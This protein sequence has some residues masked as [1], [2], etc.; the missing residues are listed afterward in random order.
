MKTLQVAKSLARS[1]ATATKAI[2][3]VLSTRA[4][5]SQCQ[6]L[7]TCASPSP[8]RQPNGP[9][10][11]PSSSRAYAKKA[12]KANK[13]ADKAAPKSAGSSS[14]PAETA[15]DEGNPQPNPEEPYKFDDVTFVYEKLAKRYA[16]VLRQLRG[17][18][19][20]GDLIGGVPVQPNKKS[21]QTYPLRELATVAPLGGRRWSILA[22]EE[23][24]VGPIISAVQRS[25]DFNQQPQRNEENPLE[26]TITIEPEKPGDLE[27]HVKETCQAWRTKVRNETH[28]R[29]DLHKKWR[30]QG[31]I[32]DDDTRALE[33][34]VRDLQTKALNDIAAKEKAALASLPR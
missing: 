33:K 10:K 26:L 34:K 25:K 6:P 13:A 17:G 7:L 15:D 9:T 29:E 1:S 31:L 22:F 11:S 24:S 27:R 18:N 20:F 3:R 19:R 32:V 28:K 8:F 2:P 21:P 30:K 14:T 16:D 12:G 4:F 5:Q 23:A